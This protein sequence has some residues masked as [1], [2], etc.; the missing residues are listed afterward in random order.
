[1][2]SI[3][4]RA[5]DRE[6]EATRRTILEV[7]EVLLANGGEEGL[8]IRELCT[9]AGVTPPTVYHH[10]GDKRALVDRVVDDCFA[11]F[12]REIDTWVGPDDPVE[13]LRAGFDHYVDYGLRHPIHYR[14]MFEQCHPA[15][16]ATG[17]AA[18]DHQRRAVA[19]V[20]DA[21]RLVPP[22]EDATAAIWSAEHG[23]T[24]LLIAGFWQ[25]GH[26]ATA[27]VRDGMIAQLTRPAPSARGRKT[28][29]RS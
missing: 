3:A 4:V 25:P 13:A 2:P 5:R 16:S 14:V 6:S 20:A 1:M 10:F 9:R 26:P 22:V 17:M 27:L 21:G 28:K 29:R 7:A 23:V 19:A 12:V 18:Y 24:S 15:P 11:A 8:S